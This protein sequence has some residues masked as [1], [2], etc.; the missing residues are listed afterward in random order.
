MLVF[1]FSF[2]YYIW[3]VLYLVEISFRKCC[4]EFEL[5]SIFL[6]VFF[7]FIYKCMVFSN[8]G[9]LVEIIFIKNVNKNN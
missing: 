6:G 4:C 3:R 2:T 8:V 9:N 1:V 5:I 7:F